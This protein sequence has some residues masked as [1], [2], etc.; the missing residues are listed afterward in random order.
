[1]RP[2]LLVATK[3]AA[4][5]TIFA[6][7]SDA[8]ALPPGV[9]ACSSRSNGLNVTFHGGS[10]GYTV[11]KNPVVNLI[12]WGNYWGTT[13][14]YDS[15]WSNGLANSPAFYTRMR[16]YGVGPGS[17]GHS[18]I[19]SN[20]V[21]GTAGSPQSL[22]DPAIG[23]GIQA[24]LNSQTPPV[25]P[26]PNDTYLVFLPPYTSATGDTVGI[27]HHYY[28]QGSGNTYIWGDVEWDNN[29]IVDK[30]NNL[31]HELIEMFTDPT[32]ES[33]FA[34]AT[35]NQTEIAD[36]CNGRPDGDGSGACNGALYVG[37]ACIGGQQS[38]RLW[39]QAACRCV[40]I[41]DLNQVD[42]LGSGVPD[43]AVFRPSQVEWYGQNFPVNG[44]SGWIWGQSSDIPFAGD[45][46]GDG[47][48]EYALFRGA[49]S[50]M[51]SLNVLSGSSVTVSIGAAG[52]YP[53]VG[54]YDGDG[55]SD[56]AVWQPSLGWRVFPSS[57]HPTGP[58]LLTVGSAGGNPGNPI[59]W[60]TT[61]DIPV[62][63]DYDGDGMTDFAIARPSDGTWQVLPSTNPTGPGSVFHSG[64]VPGDIPV[65]G[66]YN[67]DGVADWAY[68]HPADGTWHV[69][70]QLANLAYTLQWG[71]A[72]LGD[73]PVARDF[74]GD[75]MADP[76]VWRSSTGQWFVYQTTNWQGQQPVQQWGT[77][78]DYPLEEPAS[79][80]LTAH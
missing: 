20:G 18:Y 56:Y 77:S 41:R 6:L 37:P 47:R 15:Y 42:V 32:I 1:M 66:D 71:S 16:E 44:T 51:F 63:G 28:Y 23:Q 17:F 14:P 27:A 36:L 25:T 64:M 39:S 22:S 72:A 52:D 45:F 76:A 38:A 70:Y 40:S 69:T 30:M 55:M 34:G 59:I 10:A 31:T 33:Y 7:S 49:T 68:W 48:T 21:Q 60:G 74:D 13:K 46:N 4:A 35:E 73:I 50:N 62:P 11:I 24:L 3:V 58:G 26:G 29:Q 54:D 75:W 43:F 8:S 61:G 5:A 78:G 19:Y 53:V 80:L 12:Y 2:A 67:G 9:T 57:T 65:P 79:M